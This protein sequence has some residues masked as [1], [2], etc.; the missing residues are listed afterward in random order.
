MSW[1]YVLVAVTMAAA[2][3]QASAEPSEK[4]NSPLVKAALGLQSPLLKVGEPF[5]V[6]RSRIPEHLRS[7][8]AHARSSC[9]APYSFTRGEVAARWCA[10]GT[11]RKIDEGHSSLSSVTSFC[12]MA[13]Q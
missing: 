13:L 12:G 7:R 5:L 1:K 8:S 6:A 11:D 4:A 2:S 10:I 3:S 9:D